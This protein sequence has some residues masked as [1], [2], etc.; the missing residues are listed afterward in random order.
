MCIII[1]YKELFA[2]SNIFFNFRALL[3]SFLFTNCVFPISLC[4]Q[5]IFLAVNLEKMRF[6][7]QREK[8]RSKYL[9]Y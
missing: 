6:L 4:V 9:I 3:L 1:Y 8:Y 7:Y 2:Q 5:K